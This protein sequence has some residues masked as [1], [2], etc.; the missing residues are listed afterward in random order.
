MPE[1]GEWEDKGGSCSG[2]RSLGDCQWLLLV[3]G[4]CTRTRTKYRIL[5]VLIGCRRYLNEREENHPY[6]TR[7]ILN[8]CIAM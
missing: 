3:L 1:L 2:G 7:R 4:G 6:Y 5:K 8:A